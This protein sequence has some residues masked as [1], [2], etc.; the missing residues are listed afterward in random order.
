MNA[1]VLV[2]AAICTWAGLGVHASW[3]DLR[4]ATI[5]RRACWVAGIA[6]ALLLAG[7][8]IALEDPLRWLWTLAGAAAVALLLEVAYRW[9]PD[10]L[11]YGDVRLIIVN[12]FM[13]AW[14]GPAWPWWA[15]VA[16]AIAAWPAALM[17]AVREGRQARVRWAPGLTLG[18]ALVVA[19]QAVTV[20]P[21]G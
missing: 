1:D 16:G 18:T 12:S 15:L 13:V 9:R 6:V 2:W 11:G 14:W 5:S 3:T 20:G 8:A 19:W 4:A 7:A 17:S 10:R 21:L